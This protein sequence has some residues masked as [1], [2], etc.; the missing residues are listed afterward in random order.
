MTVYV[1]DYSA[2]F[3]GMIMCHM[4]SD[5][6]VDELHEFA[7]AL[8]LKRFWFQDGSAPHYDVSRSK[9]SVALQMG[10][11]HLPLRVRGKY[12]PE[13]KRVYDQARKLKVVHHG[14]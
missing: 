1:D 6:S 5:T 8:G 11:L 3:R 14:E 12:N 10:A 13:W 4:M 2:G 7:E 9:R